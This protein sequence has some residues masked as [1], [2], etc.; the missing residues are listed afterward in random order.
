MHKTLLCLAVALALAGCA[1]TQPVAPKL[2]LP[3]PTATAEQNELLEHWWTAFDDPALTAL[4]E[5]AYANNLDLR[6]TLARIEV[7]QAQ[8]L[9]AEYYLY[10]NLFLN[11]G[12]SR[13]R[14]SQVDG[15]SNNSNQGGNGSS[16]SGGNVVQNS[17][18]LGFQAS[19]EIDLW[20]KYRSSA[21][22]A[23]NDLTASRYYRETVRIMVAA[24]VARAYFQL[25]AAD[26]LLVVLVDTRK[27]RAETVTLQRD[28]FEAGRIGEYD[29]RQAEAELSA[30]EAD[31]ARA[32]QSIGLL[33]S[34]LAALT[35]RSPRE[36]FTPVIA[37]GATIEAATAVPQL[38][39]G[40]PSGLLARR[41]DIR[42]AE[43]LLASSELRIQQA[44]A[45]YFPNIQ[46]TGAY[47]WEGTSLANLFSV[48]ALAWSLAV[49]LVQPILALKPIEAAVMTAEARR[50]E[51]TV[52]YEQ[53]VQ[54]A[55]RDVHDALVVNGT[56]QRILAAE[57]HRRDQ[58]KKALEVA[59]LRYDAGRTSFL[60]VLDAQRTLLAA[61]TLRI[62]AARD[63]RISIVD[64]ARAIGGGWKTDS[65]AAVN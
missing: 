14:Y 21:L 32:R 8:V 5:E 39:E 29:L 1:V 60:E 26:A 34:G 47:G 12:A 44:R 11:A 46:L 16:S 15:N 53:T 48:P 9:L 3:A 7:A 51:V 31:I 30:I 65:V 37:R 62:G 25:R 38:P 52:Q 43:A 28:R 20:G 40:L 22:A 17:V 41:P 19:Y 54:L 33:E 18:S 56:A 49:A 10:P 55:F 36:V 23:T 50:D 6:V 58:L 64:F 59:T 24:E 35:G 61:E 63:A 4:I 42:R 45:D 2:D 13:N 57:T 27:A